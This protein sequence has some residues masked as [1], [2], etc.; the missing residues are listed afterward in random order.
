[1]F[2]PWGLRKPVPLSGLNIAGGSNAQSMPGNTA[3]AGSGKGMA[4]RRKAQKHV[5]PAGSAVLCVCLAAYVNLYLPFYPAF[6]YLLSLL[7]AYVRKNCRYASLGT[8]WPC[9]FCAT[10]S[11]CACK[12]CTAN[13]ALV[14]APVL[15]A[16]EPGRYNLEVESAITYIKDLQAHHITCAAGKG[17]AH[18]LPSG[19]RGGCRDG[20]QFHPCLQPNTDASAFTRR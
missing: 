9:L 5:S 15:Q 13:C 2:V 10:G 8:C 17:L 16:H 1:M 18:G 11:R 4:R 19:I 3:V 20:S 6:T 14:R 12:P 7:S